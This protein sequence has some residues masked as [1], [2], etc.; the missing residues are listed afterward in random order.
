MLLIHLSDIHFRKGEV[1]TAM[2][3]NAHL[4]GELLSDAVAQCE[5]IG[6]APD[7]VLVS[8]DVAFGGDPDE[9]AYALSWLDEL[10]RALSTTLSSVFVIP[11]NHDVLRSVAS[12]TLIQT[13]HRTIKST[14]DI[15]LDSLLRGLL[16]MSGVGRV[17]VWRGCFRS[18]M[19][20]AA[21]F[22]WR[23]LRSST[24]APF[25][26]PSH[27]TGRADC[28]H[29]ALGQDLTPSSTTRRAQAGSGVRA[30][31]ARRG[32]RVDSSRPL[33]A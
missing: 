3:P 20:V 22:V 12:R 11:G 5:R 33:V 25:P 18:S 14:N 17:G 7:A 19:S 13:I 9:Y 15:A 8:G 27:R 4:R 21:P 28:P 2:D 6:A 29:P 1:G 16:T 30:R 31:S 24:I 32:A 26:H 10:C 23:C